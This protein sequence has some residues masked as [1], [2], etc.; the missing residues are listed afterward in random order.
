MKDLI[1]GDR[2]FFAKK[3]ILAL[4]AAAAL[5]SGAG[6]CASSDVSKNPEIASEVQEAL[7]TD[8][9]APVMVARAMW[10]PNSSGFGSTGDT[11]LGRASGVL[12]LAGNQLWFLAWDD[13]EKHF[14]VLRTVDFLSAASLRVDRLGPARLLV[15]QEKNLGFDA[16]ELMRAGAFA[17]DGPATEALYAKL[18]AL[19]AANPQPAPP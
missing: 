1:A 18:E 6:G 2:R 14:D 13:Q 15:I 5:L 8:V 3:R 7:P 16:F 9:P 12:A 11:T 10:F 19:R 4:A 17:S